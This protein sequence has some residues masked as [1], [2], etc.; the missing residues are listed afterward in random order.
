MAEADA[1][2]TQ[3]NKLNHYSD[4]AGYGRPPAATR[5][6]PGTSGNP[7]GRP[8][9]R[10]TGLPYEAVLGQLV[11][12][13]EDVCERRVSAAEAF[14]LHMAKSGLAGNG[15]A[16]RAAMAAL[17]NARVARG[18]CDHDPLKVLTVSFVSAKDA[19]SG[20]RTLNMI[21]MLDPCRATVRIRI[22]PWLVQVAL[23]RLG[24][25]RLTLVEQAEVWRA[26]RSPGKVLWPAWWEL[27]PELLAAIP[28]VVHP[29]A[30]P[31][32]NE[33]KRTP[34]LKI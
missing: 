25:R 27:T 17:A 24:E 34:P 19:I 15:A 9:G 8:R 6:A 21:R 31:D 30:V 3:R 7:K 1:G 20:L 22:E 12:I 26:T 11:T 33:F 28:V 13:R 14:L 2:M 32:V 4:S 18:E 16:A 23:E 5:F 10:R 29:K